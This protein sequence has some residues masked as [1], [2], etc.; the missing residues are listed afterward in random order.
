MI[1]KLSLYIA[2]FVLILTN[3]AFAAEIDVNTFVNTYGQE[4]QNIIKSNL[5]YTGTENATSA[6]T[7]KI[8]P[9]GSVTDIKLEQESGTD[10]DKAVIE[11]V[12]KSAPFKPFPKEINLT[13]ITMTSGFQHKVQKYRSARMSIMPV[14]PSAQTQEAYKQYM[15]EVSKYIFDRIPTVYS[16]IPQEPVIKCTI[17]KDGTI[18]N[19]EVTK[20]SGIEEYDKKI[21]ETYTGMKVS[22][23]PDDLKMYDE[24]PY[25]ATVLRQF[26]KSPT[27]GA[28]GGYM[29]R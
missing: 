23:F 17:L 11:A 20:S 12:Q 24:L 13:D 22:P 27:L 8:H 14:E 15:S 1:K 16:Y 6:V 19:V 21:V 28:P 2:V 25:S 26:R 10:F 4:V 3:I 9:D 5:H 7:Y 18:K 29:F